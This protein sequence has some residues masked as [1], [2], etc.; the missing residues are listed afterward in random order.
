MTPGKRTY[1]LKLGELTLKRGNKHVFEKILVRNLSAMLKGSAAQT[2][3]HD[4]RFFIRCTGE[5]SQRVEDTLNHLPGITGWAKVCEV[6]KSVNAVIEA[7]VKEAQLCVEG[8]SRSFK[9]ET[10]RTDKSFP[11]R[12]YELNCMAGNAI[13]EAL[14]DFRVDVHKPDAI[15]R[16]EIRERAYIYGAEKKGLRGLPVGTAGRGLLLLSGGIDSPVAGFL[17]ALR[18]MS[19]AAVYFHS[20]PYTSDDAKQKVIDLAALL[21]SYTLGLKLCV[22]S[23]TAVQQR[24][25]EYAPEEWSTVL[26]RMAM[27]ECASSVAHYHKCKCLITGESLG[28]VAS[29]TIENLTCS[30]SRAQLPVFRPLIGFDKEAITKKAVEIGS[31]PISIRPYDD[32]CALFSPAHPVL[33]GNTS[34][35]AQLYSELELDEILHDALQTREYY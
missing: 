28:Q 24:I 21:R 35:A 33:R 30:E 16:V 32:C 22:I 4:G 19:L 18:G 31:F 17:M 10:R 27:M 7:C 14:P 20:Y 26:L 29:Q 12:S 2:I 23:F 13:C 8:G 1:L 25:K 6:E 15:I 34:T 9:L 5:V 3:T 11:L